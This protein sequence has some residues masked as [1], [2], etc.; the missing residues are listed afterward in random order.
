MNVIQCIEK[1]YGLDAGWLAR[2]VKKAT[3]LQS[4]QRCTTTET[5]QA[6]YTFFQRCISSVD[7][8]LEMHLWIAS[9]LGETPTSSGAPQ[10]SAL[11]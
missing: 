11:S 1:Q 3:P 10:C 5:L 4:V 2:I 8:Q 6:V 7:Q 9:L